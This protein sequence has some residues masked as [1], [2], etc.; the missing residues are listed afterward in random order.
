MQKI[1]ASPAG[2]YFGRCWFVRK[3]PEMDGRM[4]NVTGRMK[5][6]DRGLGISDPLEL[7]PFHSS[8]CYQRRYQMLIFGIYGWEK[9]EALG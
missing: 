6:R 9:N 7:S 3:F 4:A 1:S 8:R 2:G 5:M